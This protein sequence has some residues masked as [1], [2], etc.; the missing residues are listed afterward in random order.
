MKKIIGMLALAALA[1]GASADTKVYSGSFSG[2]PNY[3]E[4][5][6]FQKFDS[7]LGTLESI[8]WSLTFNIDDGQ[9]GVDNESDTETATVTVKLGATATVQSDRDL[10]LYDFDVALQNTDTF[11]LDIDDGDDGDTVQTT[12]TDYDVMYGSALNGSTANYIDSNDFDA[13]QSVGG[14]GENDVTVE[15]DSILDFGGNGGV[16]GSFSPLTSNGEL[17]L[18][19]T[20]AA[21]PEPATIGM[22]ALVVGGAVMIR[23]RFY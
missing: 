5:L 18:T 9:L 14:I 1:V 8:T 11:T 23:R 12:G 16:S 4:I 7:S 6:S 10:G 13:W 2:T 20:Y 21:I 3:T 22:M 15:I 19:Y 17:T